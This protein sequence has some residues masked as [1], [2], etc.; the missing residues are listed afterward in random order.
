MK[1]ATNYCNL[2]KL[3]ENTT[4]KLLCFII[5]SFIKISIRNKIHKCIMPGTRER[6]LLICFPHIWFAKAVLCLNIH[7]LLKSKGGLIFM[8][9]LNC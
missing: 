5:L 4:F 9:N 3:Q 1:Y 2:F 8:L 6:S 7:P